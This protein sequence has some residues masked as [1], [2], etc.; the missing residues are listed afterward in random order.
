MKI[1]KFEATN[2]KRLR[3]VEIRPDSSAVVIG[4]KNGAGKSSVIDGIAYTIGGKKL[5]PKVPIRRGENEADTALDLG[6]I[7]V[8]RHWVKDGRT[9]L[10]VTSPDGAKYPSPQRILDELLG[11]TPLS[12]DP[13]EFSRM[14]PAKQAEI[15][16]ELVGLDFTELDAKRRAAYDNRTAVNRELKA[17]EA[18]RKV[19][20]FHED[21]PT[22]PVSVAD[23]MHKLEERR[24]ANQAK[25]E[26]RRT[27]ARKRTD[28]ARAADDAR[29]HE[30]ETIA[31]SERLL[32]ELE[33]EVSEAYRRYEA[34]KS[35][36]LEANTDTAANVG[37]FKQ[38]T[39]K[40]AAA[41]AAG[42][43]EIDA[44]IKQ[45]IDEPTDDL[46]AEI[47]GAER[48][49]TRIAENKRC[50]DHNRTI[51]EFRKTS[52]RHTAEIAKCDAERLATIE[53]ATF[54]IDGLAIGEDGVVFN[55]LP[56]EQASSAEQLRIS[57]AIALALTPKLPIV[58]VRDGS[59]LDEDSLQ[60]V[61]SMVS[62]VKDGQ[63]WIERVGTGGA[64]VVIED[65]TIAGTD[66]KASE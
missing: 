8:F 15:L 56:L 54:P 41:L 63:L 36:L 38:A 61:Q 53:A 51:A 28:L 23:L 14:T 37:A 66:T 27:L 62:K 32:S 11:P 60:L 58:L 21:A 24:A 19:L 29:R 46:V 40:A 50:D 4:G 48:V 1:I 3:A 25:D 26:Q 12:F 5:C 18:Q 17:A 22:E 31:A 33:A 16:R 42:E 55:G 10:T 34:L 47:K 20:T 44:E 59:L 6:D 9:D 52:E 43:L 57:V 45:I 49:N 30:T 65:G 13:I 2:V 64:T 7:R 39:E 35:K